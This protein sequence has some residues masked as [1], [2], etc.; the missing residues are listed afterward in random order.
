VP[1]VIDGF[2][3]SQGF[4]ALRKTPDIKVNMCSPSYSAGEGEGEPPREWN[5]QSAMGKAWQ[6]GC[7]GPFRIEDLES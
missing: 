5:D 3:F 7:A 2:R 1:E 6:V 4:S